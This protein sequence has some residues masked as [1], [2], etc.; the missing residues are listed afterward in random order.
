MMINENEECIGVE[1]TLPRELIDW[2]SEQRLAMRQDSDVGYDEYSGLNHPA[3][4]AVF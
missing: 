3:Q 1:S 2:L 4:D